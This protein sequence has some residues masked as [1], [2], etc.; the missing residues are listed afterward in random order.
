MP[1][2]IRCPSCDATLRVPENL[3]G[4]NVK[5]PKCQTTFLAE[6]DAPAEPEAPPPSTAR[7]RPSLPEDEEGIADEPIPKSRRRPAPADED[8]E[9]LPPEEDEDRPRRRKRRRGG[10]LSFA[11]ESLSGPA[12]ALMVV[13]GIDIALGVLN[14]LAPVL[15]FSLM[16][17]GPG[18]AGKAAGN[19]DFMINMVSGFI[20]GILNLVFGSLIIF[21]AMKMKQAQSYGLAMTACVLAMIPCV[22]CCILGLPFGI[23]GITVLNKPEVK[24]AFS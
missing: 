16:A 23:W 1:E 2:Q 3:L 5:C 7:R 20:Q 22:N 4:K 8:E 10:R 19:P 9:E 18:G 13:G 17:G 15:G 24:D 12:T 21:G 14:F 6:L 11:M